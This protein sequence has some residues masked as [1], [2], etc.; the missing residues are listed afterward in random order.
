MLAEAV[1]AVVIGIAVL[2]LVL[3]PLVTGPEPAASTEP[4]PVDL[5]EL[6]ET[7]KGRA[8]TAL[9]EIEFDRATGKL[10]DDDYRML[11]DRYQAEALEAMREE[12]RETPAPAPGPDQIE[13][14]VAARLRVIRAAPASSACPRCG[15][16]PEPDA[17]F[18]SSC[19]D[20]LA[21]PGACGRCGASVRSDARFCEACG[22]RVAA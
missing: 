10:S 9:K 16:R 11:H 5:G 14:L 8:I 1:A 6:E 7:R 2:V 20:R 12:E 13:S 18:C 3:E 15:P 21:P 17:A 22:N 4:E 19:G